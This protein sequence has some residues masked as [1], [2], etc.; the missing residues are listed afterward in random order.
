M[1]VRC[2]LTKLHGTEKAAVISAARSMQLVDFSDDLAHSEPR[3]NPF[4]GLLMHLQ[5]QGLGG[6]E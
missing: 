6:L 4:E 2:S 5:G 3:A 1:R